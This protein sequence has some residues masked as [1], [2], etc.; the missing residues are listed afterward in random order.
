MLKKTCLITGVTGQVGSHLARHLLA[1][2]HDV[3]GTVRRTSSPNL[4]RIQPLLENARFRLA[5]C[6]VT[7]FG[8]VVRLLDKY[9][10]DECYNLAAQSF[11]KA[12]FD[13]PFHTTNATYLGCLNFLEAMRVLKAATP[14]FFT[15]LYQASS[16]EM[17]G[18]SFSYETDTKFGDDVGH[19]NF[20]NVSA[21][22]INQYHWPYQD[23]QTPFCPNSPYAIAKLAAHHACRLY[24][25]SYGIFASCGI[26]FN[27]ESESRGEEFV[28]RKITRYV[29]RLAWA[30][31]AQRTIPKLQL[32]NLQASRDWSHCEDACRAMTAI[33]RHDE[34]DDFCIGT[35]ESHTVE[36]FLRTALSAA[37]EGFNG[38][39]E[40]YVEFSPDHLRPCEV[41]Y[42]RAGIS[43][44]REVLG[45]EPSI[46]LPELI[47]RMVVSDTDLAYREARMEPRNG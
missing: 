41:P 32:G 17:Y 25:E 30:K 42:L 47:R 5:P 29:G 27:T 2:G 23:E 44:A 43:K 22:E 24:R 1:E 20:R 15:R 21:E 37:N 11:V 38:P 33:I 4:G 31:A 9:S 26:I 13:E 39:L 12:S 14:D 34:P 40:E 16:S 3:V 45:W 19:G 8:S 28:T 10:F 36:H 35:G 46:F 18:G 6:D 7:D